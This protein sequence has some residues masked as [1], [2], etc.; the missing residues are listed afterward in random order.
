MPFYK[1]Y[2]TC[3][4]VRY[5]TELALNMGGTEGPHNTP[6]SAQDVH[7]Q[8]GVWPEH[9]HVLRCALNHYDSHHHTARLLLL[10]CEMHTMLCLD[11]QKFRRDSVQLSLQTVM[12]CPRWE[13]VYEQGLL[14]RT[15]TRCT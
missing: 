7:E 4:T 6:P 13:F 2:H 12:V 1:Q 11:V 5:T 8:E 15:H 9:T 14:R 10:L 3:C